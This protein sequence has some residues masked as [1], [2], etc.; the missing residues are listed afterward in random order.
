MN[1][2]FQ[3]EPGTSPTGFG[4][5]NLLRHAPYCL[6]LFGTRLDGCEEVLGVVNFRTFFVSLS[7]RSLRF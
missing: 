2:P 1:N 4:L 3:T 6:R 7:V 5:R